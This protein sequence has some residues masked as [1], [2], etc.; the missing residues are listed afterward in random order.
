MLKTN[1]IARARN[2]TKTIYSRQYRHSFAV[3]QLVKQY[4]SIASKT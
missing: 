4:V 1:S 3:S 2:Y